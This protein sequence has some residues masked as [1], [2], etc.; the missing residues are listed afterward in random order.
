M[1]SIRNQVQ[2]IGHLGKNP[3]L[4][5]FDGD[6][7]M[8]RLTLATNESYKDQ[9]GDKKTITQW[10]N[11]IAWGKLAENINLMTEKGNEV[12]IQGKLTYRS[13]KDKDGIEKF[14]TEVIA[15]EFFKLSKKAS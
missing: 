6:R 10:H 3:E 4:K 2:L 13:Y 14:V 8:V 11:I 1:N 5:T 12:A 15:Q 7:K 9:S